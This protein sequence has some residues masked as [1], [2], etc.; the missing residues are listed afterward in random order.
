MLTIRDQQM[1]AF[2]SAG[3]RRFEDKMV[4]HLMQF[5]PERCAA[6]GES[7]VRASVRQGVESAQRHGIVVEFDV[8]RYLDL[9]YALSFDFDTSPATPWA[10]AI[11]ADPA[12]TPGAKVD[13]LCAEAQRRRAGGNHVQ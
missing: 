13:R 5:W 10:A 4:R 3:L 6:I 7:A 2:R 9:M 8:A 12:R 1:R 11:L